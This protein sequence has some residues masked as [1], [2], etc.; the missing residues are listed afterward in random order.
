MEYL[1]EFLLFA[2][3]ALV[4]VVA[5]LAVIAHAVS[6][7]M[8]RGYP[9]RKGH[10][11]VTPL[12]AEYDDLENTLRM[13]SGAASKGLRQAKKQ[14]KRDE[15]QRQKEQKEKNA[16]GEERRRIYVVDFHGDIAATRVERLR[17]EVTAMLTFLTEEDEV[18]VR[19]ESAGGTVHGYGLAASQLKRI[20]DAGSKLVVAVDK[21]AA[22][23]GYLVAAVA[24]LL[25]S[26][27]FAVLGSIGVVMQLPNLNKVLKKHN[28]DY[29]LLTAG[30]YKRT[31]TV[32]GE[33]KP[34]HREKVQ[35]ELDEIHELFGD[36]LRESRPQ[37]TFE[38][39]ATG[40][41]WFGT[42]AL[43][44]NLVDEILTSDEYLLRAR[45]EADIFELHWV[46]D[47][48]PFAR[49]MAQLGEATTEML[50]RFR[51]A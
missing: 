49:F 8:H 19:L 23:G 29:E 26:A 3:K 36:F 27:P 37:I 30:K 33:N 25:I 16:S 9:R 48:N 17:R 39:V 10:L 24:S 43:D 2:A 22:S 47:R 35:Q 32:F 11:E 5:I 15:K 50:E 21:V 42:K 1:Y 18:V 13:A 38:Q 46:D 7:R 31:L 51:A 40:E 28:V 41:T 4:V 34:E 12:N 20:R 6:L 45:G 14:R 44:L